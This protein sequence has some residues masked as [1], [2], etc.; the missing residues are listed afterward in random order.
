MFK[1]TTTE[2]GTTQREDFR[3]DEFSRAITV[4]MRRGTWDQDGG[5]RVKR[6]ITS[7]H[8]APLAATHSFPFLCLIQCIVSSVFYF[9]FFFLIVVVL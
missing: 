5:W 3:I 1:A 7:T 2:T 9:F 8:L 6:Y 4:H